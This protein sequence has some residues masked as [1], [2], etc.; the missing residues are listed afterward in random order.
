MGDKE[1]I[2][3]WEGSTGSFSVSQTSCFVGMI[4][5]SLVAEFSARKYIDYD[6]VEVMFVHMFQTEGF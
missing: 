4:S 2:C 6:L 3:T 1:R 5:L